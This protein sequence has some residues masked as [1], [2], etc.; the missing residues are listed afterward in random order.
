MRKFVFRLATLLKLR[1]ADRDQRRS[2]LAHA[3]RA[4]AMIDERLDELQ[5]ELQSARQALRELAGV[6]HLAVD[7][8]LDNQRYELILMAEKKSID[9]QRKQVAAEADRRRLA[10]VEA[11]RRVKT[12]EKLRDRS[13]ER[14]RAEAQRREAK[15]LDEVGL[16]P[17][18]MRNAEL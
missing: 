10:L 8:L 12:L 2:E 18:T 17:F 5:Q 9:A 13:Q 4:L 1:A 11:D 3:Q 7:S 16:R 14:H 6:G 15:Q